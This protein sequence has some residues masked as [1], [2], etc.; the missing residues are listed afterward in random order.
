MN[1]TKPRTADDW[2]D[3]PWL[4]SPKQVCHITG[5]TKRELAKSGLQK[6]NATHGGKYRMVQVAAL[7]GVRL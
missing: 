2:R 6:H 3:L 5:L 4:L 1:T 7:C